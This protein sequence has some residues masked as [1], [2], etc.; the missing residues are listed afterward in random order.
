MFIEWFQ[1]IYFFWIVLWRI[2]LCFGI[3]QLAS[4]TWKWYAVMCNDNETIAQDPIS[5]SS[6]GGYVSDSKAFIISQQ[7][8][9][10]IL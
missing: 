3:T 4:F 2:I 8:H 7:F 10:R 1:R 6:E 5:L 9:K